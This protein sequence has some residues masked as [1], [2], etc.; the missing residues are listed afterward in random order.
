MYDLN[1]PDDGQAAQGGR[2]K[3]LKVQARGGRCPACNQPIS[4]SAVICVKCGF[5]LAEGKRMKTATGE[6]G[7]STA[8]AAKSAASAPGQSKTNRGPGGSPL[9]GA[10]AAGVISTIES[11][12]EITGP[13]TTFS[14]WG[15]PA[16]V[17]G[18][19]A[20]LL[21][22]CTYLLSG[23]PLY[24][25]PFGVLTGNESRTLLWG[26]ISIYDAVRIVVM[27]P[28]LLISMFATNAIMG[29]SFGSLKTLPLKLVSVALAVLVTAE[30]INAGVYL[31]AGS[32]ALAFIFDIVKL[33]LTYLVFHA[34]CETYF[35]ADFLESIIAYLV[36]YALP[37]LIMI[38]IAM[39]MT[40]G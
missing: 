1:Q 24:A 6:A 16:I 12:K 11:K 36:A 31:I 20:F 4:E 2:A 35:D 5:N 28:I 37:I 26:L 13:I 25:I 8:T 23:D 17:T 29:L 33:G 18:V 30:L 9:S 34:L 22:C 32:S 3:P 7:G 21:L 40:T 19:G 15:K 39:L 10:Y 14:E 38:V 27:M